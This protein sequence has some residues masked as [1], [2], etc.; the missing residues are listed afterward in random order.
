MKLP[1]LRLPAAPRD[2][3]AVLAGAAIVASGIGLRTAAP[4]WRTA[5]SLRE[6]AAAVAAQVA[7]A[8]AL[9]ALDGGT[10]DSLAARNQ[11]LVSLAPRFIAGRSP[12]DAQGDLAAR[13][14]A[15]AL[16]HQVRISRQEPRADPGAGPFPRVVMRFEAEGDARGISGWLGEL[17]SGSALLDVTELSIDAPGYATGAT[18]P[19]AQHVAVTISGLRASRGGG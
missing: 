12:A 1:R 2:R 10:R 6:R 18:Q 16:S 5:R 4:L 13:V 15:A 3:R 9:I 8:R 19:E 14:G 11:R 7:E 17:E